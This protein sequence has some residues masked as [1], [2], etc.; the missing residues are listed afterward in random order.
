MSA[1]NAQRSRAQRKRATL[2]PAA[3]YRGQ[4]QCRQR[5]GGDDRDAAAGNPER[6]NG[7]SPK[8]RQGDNGTSNTTPMHT[9]SDGIHMLPADRE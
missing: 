8:I 3:M 9:A 4:R 2:R 6:R 5:G 7:P 1:N